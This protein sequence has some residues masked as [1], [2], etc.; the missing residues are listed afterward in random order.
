MPFYCGATPLELRR[1]AISGGM[2][3]LRQSG[4]RKVKKGLSSVQE[5]LTK[6][7]K[8]PVV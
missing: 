3:S 4:I 7:M 1:A 6:T 5:I 8:D 2:T